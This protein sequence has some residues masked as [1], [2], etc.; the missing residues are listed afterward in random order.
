[1]SFPQTR[2]RGE[3]EEREEKEWRG[4][5]DNQNSSPLILESYGGLV[6]LPTSIPL[7][8]VFSHIH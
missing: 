3:G 7:D 2:E 4:E 5:L 8:N 6:F 1:M